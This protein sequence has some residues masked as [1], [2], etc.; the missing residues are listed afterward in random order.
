MESSELEK[1]VSDC[2]SA[3][4]AEFAESE[5]SDD[6]IKIVLIHAAFKN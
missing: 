2:L 6:E 3:K 1:V 5:D 4:R